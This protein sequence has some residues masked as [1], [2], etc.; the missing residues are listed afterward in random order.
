MPP[1]R[2]A[3]S[4]LA[5]LLAVLVGG[6]AVDVLPCSDEGTPTEAC[7][8]GA[9]AGLDADCYCHLTFVP[10]TPLAPRL[11]GPVATLA[12]PDDAPAALRDGVAPPLV[13]PPIG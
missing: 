1:L 8:D 13:R 3:A 12:A 6:Q 11:H 2:R 10:A 9:T 5:F 4:L 7:A